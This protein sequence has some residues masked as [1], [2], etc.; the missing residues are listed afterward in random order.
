MGYSSV[1]SPSSAAGFLSKRT[2]IFT[3]VII[4][5]SNLSTN[6]I[7]DGSLTL[8]EV[9]VTATKKDETLADLA[10]TVNVV[11][12]DKLK[13]FNITS[14][15]DVQNMTPG[16]TLKTQ[17]ARNQSISLRGIPYDPDS[18]TPGT[19]ISYINGI[20]VRSNVAFSQLYDLER[21]EI[22]RGPQGTLQGE[23]SPSGS[24][25]IYTKKANPDAVEGEL[26]QIFDDNDGSVSEFAASMPIIEG[27]LA[28][29]VAGVY[30]DSEQYG[31]ETA[32]G[33]TATTDTRSGRFNVHWLPSDTLDISFTYQYTEKNTDGLE[34]VEGSDA[35]S[36]SSAWSGAGNSGPLGT[37]NPTLGSY[38]RVSLQVGNSDVIQRNNVYNFSA[39][40]E[41]A[42]H[43]LT[44][45]G[46]Y[47]NNKNFSD[48]DLD[49]GNIFPTADRD[50]LVDT[51]FEISTAEFR[52]TNNDADFWEYV[53]G[54]YYTRSES[55]T[56]NS[57]KTIAGFTAIPGAVAPLL[58]DALTIYQPA[59]FPPGFD[60]TG[61]LGP[62]LGPSPDKLLVNSFSQI[63]VENE[64]FAIF[65]DNKFFL[66]DRTTLQAGLRWQTNNYFSKIDT[67][68]KDSAILIAGNPAPPGLNPGN[69]YQLPAGT[70]FPA[71]IPKEDQKNTAESVTGSIK[72]S[73]DVN[74]ALTVYGSYG[75]GYR[76]GGFTISP[77]QGVDSDVLKYD[78][79]TSD[80]FELGFKS[81]LENGRYQINGALYYQKFTDYIGRAKNIA[82][83][84]PD[85]N[86]IQDGVL[87]TGILG[88][89]N[90]NADAII[91]GAELEFTGLLN[92]NWLMSAAASYNDAKY[93]G[94]EVPCGSVGD[95]ADS[96]SQLATCTSDG[97]IGVEP[98]WSVNLSSEYTLP[99]LMSGIDGYV[100]S[101][102]R[103]TDNR[104]D[105]FAAVNA[106][107][108][109]KY[110]LGGYGIW[111]LYFGVRAADNQW[112]INIW[113][114]NLFDKQA[115]TDIGYEESNAGF[116]FAA[117]A[118]PSRGGDTLSSGYN[119]VSVIPERTIGISATYRFGLY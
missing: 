58:G 5:T 40:W 64:R 25:Q 83:D 115:K 50:Q 34:A 51:D 114:K 76:E 117:L 15:E 109:D 6:A 98:N 93:D 31:L 101:L 87:D 113:A 91:Q 22:L 27:V 69:L 55:F 59:T 68:A 105:D 36:S 32:N 65:A 95:M 18:S 10:E 30:Q 47:Q 71:G 12:G 92:A 79:E 77:T 119:V 100:R 81:R 53:G 112:D 118:T 38:D 23:T 42:E 43:T 60:P 67:I 94:A 29:R 99:E 66:T 89:V 102:Y 90:F 61:P 80:S 70:A 44:F 24:I 8:E 54:I 14:F 82:L 85:T 11:T 20:A 116:N 39:D 97:R 2:A 19:V 21:I 13:A 86:G 17:D 1:S 28:V 62:V 46:G 110:H 111:D 84:L 75:R 108:Y 7:A 37:G 41:V 72:L 107:L 16:L 78:E 96:G 57:N 103:F 26:R 4:A 63:P 48:R 3:A 88:G 104:D 45:L 35:Y 49:R 73:H 106:N 74:D 9:I 33:K 52:F 56:D